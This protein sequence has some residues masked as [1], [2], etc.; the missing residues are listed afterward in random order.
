M[1]SEKDFSVETSVV[2]LLDNGTAD[3]VVS[4]L[5]CAIHWRKKQ[6][7]VAPTPS[8]QKSGHSPSKPIASDVNFTWLCFEICKLISIVFTAK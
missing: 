7:A 6:G 2:G 5:I 4:Y 1:I 3:W 8:F